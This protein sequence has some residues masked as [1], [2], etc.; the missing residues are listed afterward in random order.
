YVNAGH[1]PALLV[2][3]DGSVDTLVRGDAR[4]LGLFETNSCTERR[5]DLRP[6]DAL[7][8]YSDGVTEASDAPD[9]EDA[10]SHMF[11][12]ERLADVVRHSR[13]CPPGE[14]VSRILSAVDQHCGSGRHQDDITIVI[15]RRT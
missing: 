8:C 12:D 6:G 9:A 3:N 10:S 5:I 11:G 14:V 1:V 13:E 15:L 2:R 7:V 4:P